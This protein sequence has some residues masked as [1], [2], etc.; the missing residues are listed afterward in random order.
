MICGFISAVIAAFFLGILLEGKE[1]YYA[2]E[3]AE[4]RR[5]FEDLM[6]AHKKKLEDE[7]PNA[8]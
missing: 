6:S 5:N 2:G 1:Q 4:F 7:A 3:K 8:N